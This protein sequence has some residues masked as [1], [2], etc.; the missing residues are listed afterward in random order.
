MYSPSG[1]T[2]D[3]SGNIWVADVGNNRV[4]KFPGALPAGC[5]AGYDVKQD[6]SQ[7]F[8]TIQSA[9]NALPTNLSGNECVVIRDTGT[10][11]GSVTV[12]GFT[13][14]GYQLK[15][16]ADPAFVGSAPVISPP[17]AATAAFDIMNASVTIQEVTIQPV[18][19]LNDG[20]LVSSPSVVVASVTINDPS[21]YISGAGISLGG[22]DTVQNS[23][24]SV[25]SASGIM[26]NGSGNVISASSVTDNSPNNHALIFEAGASG[27][28]VSNSYFANSSGAT[29]LVA[30]PGADNNS[31]SQSTLSANNSP[32]VAL[33]LSSATLNTF[34]GDR[35]VNPLGGAVSLVS[36]SSSNTI[37]Q[38][39]VLS[40]SSS[41]AALSIDASCLSDTIQTTR[42]SNFSGAGAIINGSSHSITQSTFTA[43]S[44]NWA[45]QIQGNGNSISQSY[46]PSL[47]PGIMIKGSSNTVSA[48]V[49]N[50]GGT[51]LELVSASD[52]LIS[53]STVASSG[54]T[55]LYLSYASSTT[56]SQSYVSGTEAAEI[57]TSTSTN[58]NG[59]AL[60]GTNSSQIAFYV[61]NQSSGVA[62][63]NDAVSGGSM[64][65]DFSLGGSGV[66]S[67][68][69]VSISGSST[70]LEID[71]Q[72]STAILSVSSVTFASLMPGATAIGFSGGVFN[73]TFSS[74]DFADNSIATNINAISL[75]TS[76][77]SSLVMSGS[78]GPRTGPGYAD[79]PNHVVVWP[80]LPLSAATYPVNNAALNNLSAISG[81][82]ASPTSTIASV[83]V[84][85]SSG[86]GFN[87]WWNGSAWIPGTPS[88][89]SAAFTGVSSGTWTWAS[90]LPSFISGVSYH[91]LV[92][93]TDAAARTQSPAANSSFVFDTTPPT[94]GV[95][96][97]INGSMVSN[98]P[99]ISGTAGALPGVAVASVS[100]EVQDLNTGYCYNPSSGFTSACPAFSPV[101]IFAG[102]WSS[103]GIPTSAWA[104]GHQYLI[105][106]SATD[107][108]GNVQN[109][110][111]FGQSSITFT[112]GGL[113]AGTFGDGEG[114]A[115]LT[116]SSSP[117]C[118]VLVATISYVVG[119][120]TI[121]AYGGMIAVNIPP[122]W[123]GLQG[124]D[125][126]NDPPLNPGFV[127]VVSSVAYGM[128]FNP[129]EI[130]S[131]TLGT[132]WMVYSASAPLSPGTTIQFV[133][134]GYPPGGPLAQGPQVFAVLVQAGPGGNLR[135]IAALPSMN[136]TP[137]P[138]ANLAFVPN[139]PLALG[140]LQNSPTMYLEV[141][142]AC[143]ISTTASVA[144]VASLS[145]SVNGNQDLNANFYSSGSTETQV[146][147]PPGASQSP[148]FY[149]NTS[150]SAPYENLIASTTVAGFGASY[151]SRYI[152]LFSSSASI[153]GVS[154][155]TGAPGSSLSASIVQNGSAD[156][157]AFINFSL[158]NPGL[159]WEVAVSS[160]PTSFYPK[161]ADF[162]GTGSPGRTVA[163]NGLN[164]MV[165]PNSFVSTGTYYVEIIAGGGAAINTSLSVSVSA[166]ASIYGVVA[167]GAGASVSVMGPS[168]GPGNSAQAD[169]SGNFVVP[170]LQSGGVYS[171]QVSS[172]LILA[173][174]PVNVST[175]TSNI[176][177]SATGTNVGTLTLPVPSYIAVSA[178]L[179]QAAQS[180]IWG[181]VSAHD[182]SYSN[183][184]NAALHF[185]QGSAQSDNGAQ[186]FGVAA[187]T[188][189]QLFLPPGTYE[190]DVNLPSINLS[191][192]VFN[193]SLTGGSSVDLPVFL[194]KQADVYGYAF[195]PAAASTGTPVSVQAFPAGSSNGQGGVFGGTFVPPGASSGIYS[196]FGLSPGSW[197]VTAR[198][199][200]YV[201]ASSTVFI[202]SN[203]DVGTATGGGFNL[204]LQTGGVIFG[205]MTVTGDS[206]QESA[207]STCGMSGSGFCVRINAYG[208]AAISGQGISV[209][210]ATS[211][212]QTSS[213]FTISGLPDGA[214]FLKSSLPGFV[215]GAQNAVVSGG[216]GGASLNMSAASDGLEINVILPG[217]GNFSDVSLGY[218]DNQGDSKS[219]DDIAQIPGFTSSGSTATAVFSG[220]NP[221]LYSIDAFNKADGI[222]RQV[223]AAVSAGTTT[224]VNLDM[225]GSTYSV[226]G[227]LSFSG[228]LSVPEPGGL[229]VMVSSAAGWIS[230][231]STMAYCV[232]GSSN[233][234]T[235]SAAQMQLL[236]AGPNNGG[237]Y[238]GTLQTPSNCSNMM[239]GGSNN[240]GN[241]NPFHVYLATIAADGTFDFSGIPPGLYQ[242]RNNSR[243]DS[244]GDSVP[245]FSQVIL[246]TGP[247]SGISFPIGSG[248]SISGSVLAPAQTSLSRQIYLRLTDQNNNPVGQ[249]LVVSFNNSSSAS[250]LFPQVPPGSYLIQAQDG[251]YPQAYAAAPL[252][253]KVG[254]QN[255][256]NQ[257][258]QLVPSGTIKFNVAIEQKTSAGAQFLRVTQ[259]NASLLPSS[260]QIQA[261]A[262]PW[263]NG[264]YG[265]AQSQGGL[266]ILDSNGQGTIAGLLPGTYDVDMAFQ[267]GPSVGSAGLVASSVSGVKVTG[268]AV[269]DVGTINA[270]L[271]D[272]ISGRVTDGSGNPLHNINLVARIAQR[273]AGV[274]LQDLSAV[275]DGN[276]YYALNGLDPNVRYY[277]I[278]A[279]YR[280]DEEH[281][282]EFLPHYEQQA[283]ESVDVSSVTS[284]NFSLAQAPYSVIGQVLAPAGGPS[285]IIPFNSGHNNGNNT[286]Q[287]P[288]PGAAVFLQKVGVPPTRTPLGDI[289][290]NTDLNGNFSIPSLATGT[291]RMTIV[292]Q[293]YSSFQENVLISSASVNLGTIT[294]SQGPTLSGTL[295][296]ASGGSPSTSQIQNLIAAAPNLSSVL[297]GSLQTNSQA[298][299]ISGYS[300]SGF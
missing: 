150:T 65:I 189:T 127:H 96:L 273:S 87:T 230:Q 80:S 145:G 270:L 179:P 234:V 148:G 265:F 216:S 289:R 169:A 170:G 208:P 93:A 103:T 156:G 98:L 207:S 37:N 128:Q 83:S 59:T 88:W 219:F 167:N 28:Q 248:Y 165:Y 63:A 16:M 102:V 92:Q 78:V 9:V 243:M 252:A 94:S 3:S 14:N 109:V 173:G 229:T 191:T 297:V 1:V 33:Q 24:V 197:T 277:D 255:L 46:V 261:V 25:Q 31:L 54:A 225:S 184:A 143:G 105:V 196:L 279:A 257:T 228:A 218:A 137:G 11:N 239:T 43:S 212:T 29:V 35:I 149:F 281:E 286:V 110:F 186:S 236:P 284:L 22:F 84:A 62:L 20:I 42:V 260:F 130:S 293:G 195:L 50:T 294:M 194:S 40:T 267:N 250:F 133:Y 74:V 292:S 151:A 266:L 241:A 89:N 79:D 221:G 296:T 269:T 190:V 223:S 278:Y 174:A 139:S 5:A 206:S 56:V 113:G 180:E 271:G 138:A 34:N 41:Y 152:Q 166:G 115:T 237:F 129:A 125:S 299:T 268:G 141:T 119:A 97:P 57:F 192:S 38:S 246:V 10:Y 157:V 118:Q 116:P 76:T 47:S 27:N 134:K 280:G 240:Q 104:S 95:A 66:L 86:P 111:N 203:A 85:L 147:I 168:V 44:G 202:S 45:L 23:T 49:I 253:V 164:D 108:A 224:A 231:V 122:G 227:S 214:Y 295:A 259:N 232:M 135:P 188:W 58:I 183:T 251:G 142:D 126:A 172:M 182:A 238:G 140:P 187:S 69:S 32:S 245:Q 4:I 247:V 222:F 13:N 272:Q 21:S 193:V 235:L 158:S 258:L 185:S 91:V 114:S 282:G 6:G 204:T 12:Q 201:D 300:V 2:V 264:G 160:S 287:A 71:S 55:G 26:L 121:Q 75:S 112:F 276:G 30:G 210:L 285:L 256:S 48:S 200:G 132:N 263:F 298:Q 220:L 175:G 198:S 144:V 213:T 77:G 274:Q 226:Q 53:Q 155:D 39:V 17:T 81:T 19:S 275:T 146:I 244:S 64:G 61:T 131:Q 7:N 290:F 171:V 124:E 215:G 117:G 209:H 90:V 100:I 52:S 205:T 211:A 262:D 176:T 101:S 254:G 99:T 233:G 242:L 73:S 288:Q 120:S 153:S 181:G 60:I 51:A 136:L 162:F 106:S 199:M 15:I 18:G 161:V 177:A 159:G 217:G 249:Q 82:A 291:Y 72:T 70:G 283:D 154:V 67:L 36:G 68:S 163:W 178:T 123:S 8:T 107:A